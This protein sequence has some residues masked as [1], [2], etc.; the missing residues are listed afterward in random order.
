MDG[1]H[2]EKIH[3]RR[4]NLDGKDLGV[5]K[6]GH[7]LPWGAEIQRKKRLRVVS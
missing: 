6:R 3:R 1:E 7:S 2:S 5:D 4:L